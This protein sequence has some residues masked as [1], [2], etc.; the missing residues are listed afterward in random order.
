MAT[1]TEAQGLPRGGGQL[2]RGWK[3]FM[4]GTGA[5]VLL[6][7]FAYS[8]EIGQGMIVTGQRDIGT[9]GGAT[10]GLDIAFVVYFVGVS[11]AG[12]TIAAVI[13]LF[14]LRHLR[15]LARMA[16]V[17]TVVSL[18]L[19]AL[20][21]LVDLGQPLRGIVNLFRYARPQSPFFGTFTLVISGYLFA[22]IV[23]LYLDGR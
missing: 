17:L 19:G 18:L 4:I 11:F 7:V 9:M 6:G 8:R 16:E 14:D 23:Y 2:T 5:L 20:A 3:L 13:R 12:I 1:A 10:W 22:S 21:I 15:P